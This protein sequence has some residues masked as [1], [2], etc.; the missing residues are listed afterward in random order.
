[1]KEKDKEKEVC[2]FVIFGIAGSPCFYCLDLNISVC[3]AL[4]DSD[5]EI[6]VIHFPKHRC[7]FTIMIVQSLLALKASWDRYRYSPPQVPL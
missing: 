6:I 4:L 3:F 2:D 7:F 1:M 5:E